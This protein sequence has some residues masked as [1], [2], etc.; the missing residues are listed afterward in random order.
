M[1]AQTTDAPPFLTMTEQEAQFAG[2]VLSAVIK[3]GQDTSNRLLTFAE[4]E[5][6]EAQEAL[7]NLFREISLVHERS[8][9]AIRGIDAV[10][11]RWAPAANAAGWAIESRESFR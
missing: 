6:N 8:P 9:I 7:V 11:D 3:Q 4:Q 2:D 1:D 5:R 10:L